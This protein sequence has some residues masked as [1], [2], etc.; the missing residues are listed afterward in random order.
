MLCCQGVVEFNN[1]IPISSIAGLP[2][3]A[4]ALFGVDRGHIWNPGRKMQGSGLAV[5]CGST[6]NLIGR[7]KIKGCEWHEGRAHHQNRLDISS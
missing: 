2:D 7:S 1:C 5:H 4:L 3:E 6:L